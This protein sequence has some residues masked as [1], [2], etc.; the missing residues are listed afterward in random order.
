MIEDITMAAIND[1]VTKLEKI[2]KEKI[3]Q[4]TS[5]LQLPTDFGDETDSDN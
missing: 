3:S 5:G 1:A 4:L 2:S